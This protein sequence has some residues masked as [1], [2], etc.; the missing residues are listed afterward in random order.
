MRS[1]LAQIRQS[2][3]A[4]SAIN[5]PSAGFVPRS[6]GVGTPSLSD[7]IPGTADSSIGT[8]NATSNSRQ[9]SKWGLQ[10]ERISRD[11][12]KGMLDALTRLRAIRERSDQ[13]ELSKMQSD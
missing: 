6:S 11:A 4:P 10:E 13:A 9:Q 1:A 8:S 2:R 12:W 3:V 7:G 5:A